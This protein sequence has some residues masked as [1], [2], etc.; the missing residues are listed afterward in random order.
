MSTQSTTHCYC[1]ATFQEVAKREE[2]VNGYATD[3]ERQLRSRSR[4]TSQALTALLREIE[5]AR[6]R[7]D[8][9]AASAVPP[10]AKQRLQELQT[11]GNGCR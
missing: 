1:S 7:A 6:A 11:G 4:A 9:A 8:A 2:E 10:D 5:R 3:V